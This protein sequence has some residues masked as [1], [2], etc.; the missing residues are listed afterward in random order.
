MPTCADNS[1]KLTMKISRA[2]WGTT[3][4]TIPIGTYNVDVNSANN[5]IAAFPMYNTIIGQGLGAQ[6]ATASISFRKAADTPRL[7]ACK[8]S[9]IINSQGKTPVSSTKCIPGTDGRIELYADIF[10]LPGMLDPLATTPTV[11]YQGGVSWNPRFT[12]SVVD[13][14]SVRFGEH[15]TNLSINNL[16]FNSIY[17][18]RY[19]NDGFMSR[20]LP[21]VVDSSSPLGR[22]LGPAN[23]FGGNV[24]IQGNEQNRWETLSFLYPLSSQGVGPYNFSLPFNGD[25]VIS[26][27]LTH[28]WTINYSTPG[29]PYWQSPGYVIN[30]GQQTG[31]LGSPTNTPSEIFNSFVYSELYATSRDH[32]GVPRSLALT[33]G[34]TYKFLISIDTP[35]IL[36]GVFPVT[37]PDL[38]FIDLI[39]GPCE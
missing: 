24:G 9:T 29:A 26:Q 15:H 19:G 20:R 23:P 34:K 21:I 28:D 8:S 1:V 35:N 10:F 12:P 14:Y 27:P 3:T 2:N 33:P 36:F 18:G 32:F 16:T 30:G 31:P 17:R 7:P 22:S 25:N 4:S 38:V 39:C 5:Y 13:N 37:L 6:C 11:N